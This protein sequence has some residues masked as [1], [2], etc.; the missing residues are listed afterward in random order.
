MKPKGKVAK[1]RMSNRHTFR[2][3]V[4]TGEVIEAPARVIAAEPPQA[5]HRAAKQKGQP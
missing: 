4:E 3:K 2:F 5:S 1:G